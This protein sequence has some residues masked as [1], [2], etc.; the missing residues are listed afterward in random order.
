MEVRRQH[1]KLIR[2]RL[3]QVLAER[4]V[5][6]T[7]RTMEEPE[8]REK[9]HHKL[10]EEVD[11]YLLSRETSELVDVLE[12][13]KALAALQGVNWEQLESMRVEKADLRGGFEGRL[14]LIETLEEVAQ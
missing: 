13:V 2:D 5:T 1:H 7:T 12:V 8:Y 11:E 14:L 4:G 9:L 10:R 6:C 3:P